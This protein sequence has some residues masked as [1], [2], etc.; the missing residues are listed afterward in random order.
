MGRRHGGGGA[1]RGHGMTIEDPL[2]LAREVLEC[3]GVVV[4]QRRVDSARVG[5]LANDT[6]FRNY[7]N[8]AASASPRSSRE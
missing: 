7:E 3:W 8:R 4:S 6:D 2:D 1:W 5:L